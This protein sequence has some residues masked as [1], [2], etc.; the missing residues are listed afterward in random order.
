MLNNNLVLDSQPTDNS[1]IMTLVIG[2]RTDKGIVLASDSQT[3]NVDGR[4]YEN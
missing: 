1:A 2:L 3:T 4:I